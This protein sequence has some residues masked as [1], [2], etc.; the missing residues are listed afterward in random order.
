MVMFFDL[1]EIVQCSLLVIL[2]PDDV[3]AKKTIHAKSNFCAFPES[4][5]KRTEVHA[6]CVHQ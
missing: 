4:P 3:S 1:V 6:P 2:N 5:P